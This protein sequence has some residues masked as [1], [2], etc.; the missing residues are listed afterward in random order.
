MTAILQ[1]I[2]DF[3]TILTNFMTLIAPNVIAG[4]LS[5]IFNLISITFIIMTTYLIYDW[6]TSK[7]KS[8]II[9]IGC[10][11]IFATIII[12]GFLSL[13]LLFEVPF[14][15][16]ITPSFTHEHYSN[17]VI[18][19]NKKQI[20]TNNSNVQW[21]ILYNEGPFGSIT[22][23]EFTRS[24]I[25]SSL[26][27]NDWVFAILEGQK[28]DTTNRVVARLQK[29][30]IHVTKTDNAKKYPD[31]VSYKITKIETKDGSLTET[32]YHKSQTIKFKELYLEIIADVQP[33]QLK[34]ATTDAQEKQNKKDINK[35]L[36]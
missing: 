13:L 18:K 27:N 19:S 23:N 34:D 30:N 35:L 4:G 9:Q 24:D 36:N 25:L 3:Y 16:E 26:P 20:Y 28:G 6:F 33:E 31:Y 1:S 11:T 2:L 17:I 15:P 29:E 10:L 5:N 21:I 8:P 14:L 32:S 7:T 12:S 22:T